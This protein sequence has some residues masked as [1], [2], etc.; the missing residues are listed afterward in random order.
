MEN[1]AQENEKAIS[2]AINGLE[3]IM[4]ETHRQ[5]RVVGS[6]PDGYS[7]MMLVGARFRHISTTKWGTQQY[8]NICKL[9]EGGIR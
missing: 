1:V 5:T 3:H 6:F 9:Y 4:K 8:M 2:R 7:A